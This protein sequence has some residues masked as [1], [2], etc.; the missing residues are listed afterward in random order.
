MPLGY[1][2]FQPASTTGGGGGAGED[3]HQTDQFTA[4]SKQTVF[5]LS[6]TPVDPDDVE[7]TVNGIE[8]ANG[9]DF[10]VSGTTVTWLDVLF[11]LS[12]GDCI[13]IDYDI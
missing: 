13:I 12:A 1:S 9:S 11:T 2:R 5:S 7:L 4:T 6:D 3:H 8:Y 10:S